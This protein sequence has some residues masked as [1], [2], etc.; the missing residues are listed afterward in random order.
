MLGEYEEKS[1]PTSTSIRTRACPLRGPR[2]RLVGQ[3]V[4]GHVIGSTA[5]AGGGGLDGG[6]SASPPHD[7]SSGEQEEGLQG[8]PRAIRVVH[9]LAGRS[10]CTQGG[11][12]RG[13][14]HSRNS[15]VF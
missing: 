10:R 7:V 2:V 3:S 4:V 14:I 1:V 5:D 15:E 9:V 12:E 8:E 13:G 11:G 6:V